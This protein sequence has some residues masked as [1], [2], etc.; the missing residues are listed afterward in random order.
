[1]RGCAPTLTAMART[2]TGSRRTRPRRITLVGRWPDGITFER[3]GQVARAS[4]QTRLSSPSA[5][6]FRI[7]GTSSSKILAV[8]AKIAR[9]A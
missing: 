4:Q 3:R 5:D 6:Q 1:M 8:T 2:R 7:S 9:Y